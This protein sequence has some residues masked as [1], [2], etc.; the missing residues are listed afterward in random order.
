MNIEREQT[1]T[2]TATLKLKLSP[3]DYAP[4]VEKALKEQRKNASWPGFRPGQ[5]PLAFIK[6]RRQQLGR[7]R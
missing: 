3:E 1:G 7:A 6:K 4:A 2:L 5:L